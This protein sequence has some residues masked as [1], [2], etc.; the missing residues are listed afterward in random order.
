MGGGQYGSSPYGGQ[1]GGQPNGQA[2]AGYGPGAGMPGFDGFMN[3][4]TAAM[5]MQFG[6][7]AAAMGA[8]YI[9]ANVSTWHDP[10]LLPDESQESG[11]NE[12]QH[13]LKQSVRTSTGRQVVL[14]RGS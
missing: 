8:Q 7:S 13:L 2:G 3:N 4:P 14:C 6:Q 11:K 12:S 5:G 10:T 9:E 1:M